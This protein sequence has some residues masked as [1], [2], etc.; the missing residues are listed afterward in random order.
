MIDL[1][2]LRCLSPQQ[3]EA[4]CRDLQPQGKKEGHRWFCGSIKGEPGHSFSVNFQTGI[5][6]DFAD[7]R[8]QQKGAV[9]YWMAVRGVDFRTAVWELSAWLGCCPP[10]TAPAPLIKKDPHKEVFFPPGLS[11]PTEADRWSLSKS[12]YICIEALRIAAERG[13]IQCFDDRRN[14]RCWLFS[15]QRRRC[16]LRRRLD[17]LPFILRNGSSTKSAACPGSD[18]HSPLGYLEALAFPAVAIV[19]GAPDALSVIAHAWASGVEDQVVPISMPSRTA[20]FT[21]S[22]LGYL[23]GK[24]ARIFIDN[25]A[26]A[27]KAAQRWAAQLQSADIVVDGFSFAGLIMTDGRPIKDLNDLLTIDYDSWEQ[28]RSQVENVISFAH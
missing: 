8:K 21:E 20:N 11:A 16:G 15:D 23:Q 25:D 28:F 10:E 4:L 13:F 22:V 24:R 9:N 1:D 5:F 3:W 26:P 18:M 2:S 14:G 12:R 7:D 17:N 6:G 19:E 27:Y